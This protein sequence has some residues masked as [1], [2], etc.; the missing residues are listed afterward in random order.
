MVIFRPVMLMFWGYKWVTGVTTLLIKRYKPHLQPGGAHLHVRSAIFGESPDPGRCFFP[1]HFFERI[2]VFPKIGVPQ[3]GWFIMEIPI[4]M[5]DLGV[6]LFLETPIWK[7]PKIKFLR[8]WRKHHVD[9]ARWCG[10]YPIWKIYVLS[11]QPNWAA[12]KNLCSLLGILPHIL[13]IGLATYF[14]LISN[15]C[16]NSY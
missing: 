6:P 3:N 10:T 1:A 11:N 7:T 15:H 12:I 13:P 8:C 14:G 16:K 2:W 9:N 5:D 4:K